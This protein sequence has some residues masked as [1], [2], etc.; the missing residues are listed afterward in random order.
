MGHR[1]GGIEAAIKGMWY[2]AGPRMGL[3]SDFPK[4]EMAQWNPEQ[5]WMAD[6]TLLMQMIDDWV[7]QDADRA[8]RLTP[9]VAGNWN[10]ESAA[11]LF[12]K[13]VRDLSCCLT[14]VESRSRS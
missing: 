3:Q 4:F 12:E 8:E 14:R 10:L 1:W 11:E 7:D 5:R 6:T 2:V 13:T 9:V